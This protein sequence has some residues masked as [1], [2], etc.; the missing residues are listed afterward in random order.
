MRFWIAAALCV[1]TIGRGF[2]TAAS[3]EE[4]MVQLN[5]RDREYRNTGTITL[6]HP[7]T[8]DVLGVYD[9]ATGG[10]GRG[11]AP[12]GTYE[13]GAFRGANDDPHHIGPRW[14]IRQL[15]QSDDGEAYDPRLKETRTA[16]ELHAAQ[17]HAGSKGCIAVLGGP[18]VW[19]EFMHNLDYIIN[20]GEP[21]VFTLTG[22]S[23]AA[24][25]ASE[26][27]RSATGVKRA[28]HKHERTA[29]QGS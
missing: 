5:E 2:V 17:H 7:A 16:L 18:E 6:R 3:A 29:E 1:A 9:F 12:L 28:S 24:P 26:P 21:V 11:S 13:I 25:A 23:A 4:L 22:N 14:M 8:G 20:E 27:P 19:Q 15:G 10:F